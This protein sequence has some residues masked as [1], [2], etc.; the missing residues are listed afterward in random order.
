MPYLVHNGIY[1]RGPLFANDFGI[2]N[3]PLTWA[4]AIDYCF[5]VNISGT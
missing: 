3:K 2:F 5:T 4:D 1:D